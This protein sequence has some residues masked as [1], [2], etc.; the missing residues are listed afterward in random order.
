MTTIREQI[1]AL[2]K[3]FVKHLEAVH[4][5]ASNPE[6]WYDNYETFTKIVGACKDF[7]KILIEEGQS[8][9]IVGHAYAA[10]IIS[11]RL[12]SGIKKEHLD[13]KESVEAQI[14]FMR[15]HD[16]ARAAA[17]VCEQLSD[18]ADEWVLSVIGRYQDEFI[19]HKDFIRTTFLS[20]FPNE[21]LAYDQF[22]EYVFG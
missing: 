2:D 12:F 5:T 9:A 4:P 7:Y 6:T 19:K 11:D 8:Q 16:Q 1:R 22:I 15:V 13:N 21:K 3:R 10:L 18:E 17:L 20:K 14:V